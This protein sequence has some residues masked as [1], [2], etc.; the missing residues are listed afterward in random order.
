MKEIFGGI[1]IFVPSYYFLFFEAK[2]ECGRI[3]HWFL[4]KW[5]GF[6]QFLVK[7]IFEGF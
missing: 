3:I 1:L 6:W 7:G 2:F 4:D 5:V